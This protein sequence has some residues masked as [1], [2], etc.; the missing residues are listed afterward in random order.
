MQDHKFNPK[1]ILVPTD[2]SPSAN[3]ALSSA[4][5]LAKEFESAIYLLHIIPMLPISV[6]AGQPAALPDEEYLESSRSYAKERLINSSKALQEKG[7]DAEFGIEV[8]NDVVGNI[9]MVLAREHSD[10]VVLSTH[11][12][13]GW[14]PMIFGS[15]AEKVIKLV[16]CPLLLFHSPKAM[17]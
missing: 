5:E 14:R 17:S 3:M 16:E 1:R 12:L 7:V 10:L 9:M 11:G 8:G 6:E 13:S 15:I 2:F 4:A